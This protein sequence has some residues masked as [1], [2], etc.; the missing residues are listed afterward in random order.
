MHLGTKQSLD[1]ILATLDSEAQVPPEIFQG[2]Q[3][4]GGR[5]PAQVAIIRLE[6]SRDLFI[7]H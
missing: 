3:A 4:P 6:K 5:Q 7:S 2:D 1:D